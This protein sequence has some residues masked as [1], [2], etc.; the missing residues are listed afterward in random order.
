[1]RNGICGSQSGVDEVVGLL[2]YDAEA[3]G[4]TLLKFRRAFYFIFRI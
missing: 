3:I 4:K 1:M 2:G